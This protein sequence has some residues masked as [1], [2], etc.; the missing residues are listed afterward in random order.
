MKYST[1]WKITALKKAIKATQTVCWSMNGE[2][3]HCNL[4]FTHNE[5]RID[6]EEDDIC[7]IAIL[8]DILEDIE[9]NNK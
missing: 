7:S 5:Y 8:E 9:T 3:E 2:C 1:D 6:R 4:R